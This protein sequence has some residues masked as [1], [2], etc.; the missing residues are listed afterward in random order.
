MRSISTRWVGVV[1]AHGEV[2]LVVRR[3]RPGFVLLNQVSV[4]SDIAIMGIEARDRTQTHTTGKATAKRLLRAI[5]PHR[6]IRLAEPVSVR[7]HCTAPST[8]NT[9]AMAL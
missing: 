1:P 3:L 9:L 2:A 5:Q 8:R 6:T 7:R 4:S